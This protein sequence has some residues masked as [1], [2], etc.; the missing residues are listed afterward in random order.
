[1]ERGRPRL[2]GGAEGPRRER[3]G[4]RGRPERDEGASGQGPGPF[5]ED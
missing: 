5:V 4:E 1:M 3:D 2:G